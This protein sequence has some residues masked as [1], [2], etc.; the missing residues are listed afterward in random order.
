MQLKRQACLL[1]HFM[2]A[3][4]YYHESAIYTSIKVTE[5]T[6]AAEYFEEKLSVIITDR[7]IPVRQT[8]TAYDYHHTADAYFYAGLS[9]TDVNVKI[10]NFTIAKTHLKTS[11]EEGLDEETA[12]HMRTT[13]GEINNY[14]SDNNKIASEIVDESQRDG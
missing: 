4:A 14:L 3:A 6:K 11:L 2:K 10:K 13:L 7:E 9:A 5:F 12:Q 1:A 8:P